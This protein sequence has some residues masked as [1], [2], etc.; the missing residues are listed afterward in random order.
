MSKYQ[1]L[2]CP[3]NDYI[4]QKIIKNNPAALYIYRD[5]DGNSILASRDSGVD[6]F[7]NEE[8]SL[9]PGDTKLIGLGVKCKMIQTDT[10]Q[11]VGYYLYSR[12][13][14]CKTPLRLANSVGI[15]DADYRGEIKAPFTNTPN[16]ANYINDFSIGEDAITKYTFNIK[17]GSRYTQICSPDLSPFSIK[18]VESLDM[19]TRG[20]GG[21]GSTGNI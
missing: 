14:I 15:I 2:I 9:S 8:V 10:N 6:M 21:F 17:K 7:C 12:S 20:S 18:F 13:S 4:K 1:L 16:I 19:T 5:G 3:L 11:S